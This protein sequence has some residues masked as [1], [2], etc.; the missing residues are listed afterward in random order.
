MEAKD[1]ESM[2]QLTEDT[3]K[4]IP[5]ITSSDDHTKSVLL[6]CEKSTVKSHVKNIKSTKTKYIHRKDIVNKNFIRLLRRG[7]WDLFK[8]TCNPKTFGKNK[9]SEIYQ[10]K[11]KTFYYNSIKFNSKSSVT[12][13]DEE[14]E[15][16]CFI[17]SVIMSGNHYFPNP[18][19]ERTKVLNLFRDLV[20]TYTARNYRR[21][22]SIKEVPVLLKI[23]KETQIIDEIVK[24]N[25]H[26]A[27]KLEKYNEALNSIVNFRFDSEDTD[28]TTF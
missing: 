6:E 3:P 12:L 19:P 25:K 2:N 18:T 10:E 13:T 1:S 14:D 7:L 23:L 5:K 27:I 8:V 9:Y 11:I 26:E 28:L 15:Q 21:F 22:C 16:I 17:L 20:R 4:S 24:K